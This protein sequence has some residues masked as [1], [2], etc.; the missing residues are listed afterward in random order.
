MLG[1]A[2]FVAVVVAEEPGSVA[3][4]PVELAKES[5]KPVASILASAL[6]A[7]PLSK[8]GGSLVGC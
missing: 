7:Q 1:V 5:L 3:E 4:P 8:G 2:P 6:A